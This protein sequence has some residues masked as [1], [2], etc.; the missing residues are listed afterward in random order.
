MVPPSPGRRV[1]VLEGLVRLLE[2]TRYN[3][4]KSRQSGEFEFFGG[5]SRGRGAYGDVARD[6]TCCKG[7]VG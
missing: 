6:D 7:R 3:V 4:G 2:R 1:P 5:C